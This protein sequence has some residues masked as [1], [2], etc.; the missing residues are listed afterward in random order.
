MGDKATLIVRQIWRSEWWLVSVW[1]RLVLIMAFGLVVNLISEC[2]RRIEQKR[3]M[4]RQTRQG[5]IENVDH[6]RR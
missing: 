4:D 6:A 1:L 2:N 5:M 3:F